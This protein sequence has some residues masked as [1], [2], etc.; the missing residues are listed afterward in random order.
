MREGKGDDKSYISRTSGCRVPPGD[1]IESF[2]KYMRYSVVTTL[3]SIIRDDVGPYE[4][5]LSQ[6]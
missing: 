1:L 5:Y 3:K 6:F 4:V 2:C